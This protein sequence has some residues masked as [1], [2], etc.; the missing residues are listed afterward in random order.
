[1]LWNA[2]RPAILLGGGAS[3]AGPE[4][5]RLAETIGAPV[6]LTIN[7]KGA[8]P[9]SHPLCLGATL[10]FHPVCDLISEADVLLAV[11]TQFSHS[12]WWELDGPPQ[13][14]GSLIRV[15]ID[16]GQL[17]NPFQASIALLGDS[18]ATLRSIAAAFPGDEPQ[19]DRARL[20]FSRARE[21]VRAL[22]LPGEISGYRE[23]LDSVDAALPEDRIVVGDS[24]Q[25]VYAANHTMAAPQPRSWLMPIGYGTLGCALPMAIGAKLASPSRPVIC[26]AG[27]GGILFTVQELATASDLHLPLPIVVWSNGGYREIRG[28]ME[29]AGIAQFA[30]E[31]AAHDLVEIA[32]GFGCRAERSTGLRE[33]GSLIREALSA[34]GPTV[35]EVRP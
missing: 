19:N 33:A 20:G 24:T 21:A 5:L 3:D 17:H 34:S 18:A 26:L 22:R 10:T 6:G 8:V 29:H 27:D 9:S 12:D 13:P 30:T 32:R 11:G 35:I 31:A 25:P 7:A 28:A 2:A 23:F 4:A 1:M 15:D 14:Q 16:P